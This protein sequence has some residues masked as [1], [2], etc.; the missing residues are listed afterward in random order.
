MRDRAVLVGGCCVNRAYPYPCG[1]APCFNCCVFRCE[2]ILLGVV[3]V[4]LPAMADVDGTIRNERGAPVAGVSIAAYRRGYSITTATS[5][6]RGRF[7]IQTFPPFVIFIQQPQY[8]PL[9]AVVNDT[10]RLNLALFDHA[11]RQWSVPQCTPEERNRKGWGPLLFAFPSQGTRRSQDI[12]YEL[13]VVAGGREAERLEVWSGIYNSHGFPPSRP[14]WLSED[15]KMRARSVKFD[16]IDGIDFKAES[17]DGAVSRWVGSADHFAKYESVSRQT[18]V[19]FDR[20]IA[21]VCT[22]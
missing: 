16:G 17:A 18:S 19:S 6:V 21:T 13:V 22:K 10:K 12:D 3:I 11:G 14:G 1:V 2:R 7:R 20:I 8:E 4:T 9:V 15:A 5:D